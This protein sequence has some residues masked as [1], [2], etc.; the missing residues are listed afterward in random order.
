MAMFPKIDSPCPYKS[1]LA[2]VMDGDMCRMCKRQVFDLTEMRDEDRVAFMAGCTADEVC[3]SYR[4]PL[5]PALAAAAM[6]VSA[7]APMAAAAQEQEMD[8]VV[9]GVRAPTHATF[10]TVAANHKAPALPVVYEDEGTNA[11]IAVDASRADP[12][13][14]AEHGPAPLKVSSAAP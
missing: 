11:K 1:R 4:I 14:S 2:S 8:I 9:G 12:A 6:A 13:A 7:L 10:V 3:V 5:R